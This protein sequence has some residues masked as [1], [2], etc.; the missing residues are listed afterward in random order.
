V[1]L[2][3]ILTVRNGDAVPLLYVRVDPATDTPY[4][5]TQITAVAFTVRNMAG[6]TLATGA[7]GY[8]AALGG[9]ATSWAPGAVLDGLPGAV[10]TLVPTRAGVPPALAGTDTIL[11]HLSDVLKRQDEIEAG[12]ATAT[13]LATAQLSIEA[14]QNSTRF[15]AT[16]PTLE[17]P[18][19]GTVAYK[20]RVNL[21]DT[22]GNPEDPDGQAL[23]VTVANGAGAD[24]SAN[25]SAV[26]RLAIGRY[27]VSYSLAASHAL[28]QLV[29][30]FAYAEN[31]VAF[32]RDRT[33]TVL[34]SVEVGFTSADRT[35]LGATATAAA[36]ATAR[37]DV[38]A[39]VDA[40]PTAAEIDATL[41]TAHGPNAWGSGNPIGPDTV[42]RIDDLWRRLGLDP[43]NELDIERVSATERRFRVP[44]DGSLIDCLVTLTATSAT[45]ERQP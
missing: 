4:D 27:E 25:L 24:R 17:R 9:W 21:D 5:N 23:T 15:T 20:I 35:T 33:A 45:V 16:I 26:T 6:T 28:E 34:D 43:A 3:A 42:D 38:L 10:V 13:A 1:K 2:A 37:T 11:L 12:M 39:A 19:S 44:A 7:L 36:L 29:L 8:V 18:L 31:S 22:A 14:I 32:V 40:V 30:E 41:T